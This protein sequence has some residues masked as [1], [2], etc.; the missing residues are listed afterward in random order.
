[1]IHVKTKVTKEVSKFA[2][3]NMPFK[4]TSFF[5]SVYI[6]AIPRFFFTGKRL[7]IWDN[8]LFLLNI[9]VYV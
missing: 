3:Y 4:K 8:A 5:H 9:C 1:M 7:D 2:L 6:G